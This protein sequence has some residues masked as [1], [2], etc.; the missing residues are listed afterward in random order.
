MIT[1]REAFVSG[2]L[3]YLQLRSG[4]VFAYFLRRFSKFSYGNLTKMPHEILMVILKF[5]ELLAEVPGVAR[6]QM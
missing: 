2:M 4:V 3:H 5:I 1:V 6:D